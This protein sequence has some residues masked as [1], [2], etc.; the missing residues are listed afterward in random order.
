MEDLVTRMNRGVK[1]LEDS[2]ADSTSCVI[3]ED[4]EGVGSVWVR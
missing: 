4:G 3:W 2:K 1:E